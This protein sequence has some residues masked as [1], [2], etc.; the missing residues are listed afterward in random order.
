MPLKLKVT[1]DGQVEEISREK[2]FNDPDKDDLC[3]D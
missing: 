2:I 1:L 3:V